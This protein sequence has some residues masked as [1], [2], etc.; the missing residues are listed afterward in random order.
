MTDMDSTGDFYEEDESLEDVVAAFESGE[1]GETAPPAQSWTLFLDVHSA[2][3]T[4][5]PG[6]TFGQQVGQQQ[7]VRG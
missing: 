5:T 6:Q 3:V 2:E 4:A 1:R 7:L